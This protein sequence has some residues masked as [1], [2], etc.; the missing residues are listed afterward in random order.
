[1][2]SGA[3]VY[4]LPVLMIT[5]TVTGAVI[6]IVSAMVVKRTERA[7]GQKQRNGISD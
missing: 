3:I 2:G 4:Y 1:M 6:G 5:G 7:Y